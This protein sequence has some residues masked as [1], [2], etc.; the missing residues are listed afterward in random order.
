MAIDFGVK[1]SASRQDQLMSAIAFALYL[2]VIVGAVH[3]KSIGPLVFQDSTFLLSGA[4]WLVAYAIVSLARNQ[5]KQQRWVLRVVVQLSKEANDHLEVEKIASTIRVVE[6]H[7]I[8]LAQTKESL[9]KLIAKGQLMNAKL[10]KMDG[11]LV[12]KPTKQAQKEL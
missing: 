7:M 1:K 4:I 2:P 8:S 11:Q 12:L 10:E 3:L 9:E 6:H 5:R